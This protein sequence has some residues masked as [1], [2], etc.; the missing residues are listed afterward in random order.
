MTDANVH[1]VRLVVQQV[2]VWPTPSYHV[3]VY[4]D[5]ID[6]RH[7]KFSNAQALIETLRAAIPGLDLSDQSMNPLSEGQG[8][9]ILARGMD[10][11]EKQLAAFGS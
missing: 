9:V 5:T 6:T 4:G 10:L 1:S 11:D 3:F 8:S 2:E 7:S